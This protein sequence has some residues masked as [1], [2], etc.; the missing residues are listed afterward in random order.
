MWCLSETRTS[1]G[2]RDLCK[3]AFERMQKM[4][5]A[6]PRETLLCGKDLTTL[7][8]VLEHISYLNY[9]LMSPQE[10]LEVLFQ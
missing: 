8:K 5:G 6:D 3:G 7:W 10:N 2:A 1:G 9:F 4:F